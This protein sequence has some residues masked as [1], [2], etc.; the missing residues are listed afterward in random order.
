M[1]S[2]IEDAVRR[3]LDLNVR[4]YSEVT[5]LGVDYIRDLSAAFG[6]LR[7]EAHGAGGSHE[8]SQAGTRTDLPTARVLVLEAVAGGTATGEFVV[9]NHLHT[10]VSTRIA[11]TPF[12][13]STG[14]I[15]D[16]N[17]TFEPDDIELQPREQVLVRVKAPIG[18]GLRAGASYRGELSVPDLG[19]SGIPVVLRRR[20][21]AG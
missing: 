20:R 19:G 4:F 14:H 7:P 18:D 12:V 2:N 5:R 6:N 16:T 13:D 15:A 17:I 21:D 9:T 8:H 3:A 11:T 10:V 1:P